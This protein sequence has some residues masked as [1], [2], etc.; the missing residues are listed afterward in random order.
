MATC[1]NIA[2][3]SED[4]ALAVASVVEMRKRRDA[5]E[6]RR[7]GKRRERRQGE[8]KGPR[9]EGRGWVR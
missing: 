2:M 9:T 3:A 8:D 4:L 5:R 6:K 1:F 7:S